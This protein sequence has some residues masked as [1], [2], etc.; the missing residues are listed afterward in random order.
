MKAPVVLKANKSGELI[1]NFD[2]AEVCAIVPTAD[3]YT[4][5]NEGYKEPSLLRQFF[6][7]VDWDAEYVKKYRKVT[8]SWTAIHLNSGLKFNID[9][10]DYTTAEIREIIDGACRLPSLKGC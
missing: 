5:Q 6:G 1:A 3:T 2:A 4:L 7:R 10:R 8:K 9:E